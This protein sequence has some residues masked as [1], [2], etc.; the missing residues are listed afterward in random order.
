METKG[1]KN[2]NKIAWKE[3]GQAGSGKVEGGRI[4]KVKA[5]CC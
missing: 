1:S 5:A 2:A 3:T 4:A